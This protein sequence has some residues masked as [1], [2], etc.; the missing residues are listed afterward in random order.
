MLH[1]ELKRV[2]VLL[3]IFLYHYI[4]IVKHMQKYAFL[5]YKLMPAFKTGVNCSQHYFT[6]SL[7]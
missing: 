2:N 6:N 5:V 4:N 7:F 3:Q 1:N